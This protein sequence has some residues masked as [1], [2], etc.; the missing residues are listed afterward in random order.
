MYIDIDQTTGCVYVMDRS[1]DGKVIRF[2]TNGTV[3]TVFSM[4]NLLGSDV[5]E[6]AASTGCV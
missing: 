4:A 3:E 5:R 1:L 6:I 2:G